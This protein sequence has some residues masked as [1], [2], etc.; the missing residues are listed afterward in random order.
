[1]GKTPLYIN[2]YLGGEE[3]KMKHIANVEAA[4]HDS[5]VRLI[6]ES[7]IYK[8]RYDQSVSI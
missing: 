3:E 8:W 2:E 1:M 6:N 4:E 5:T 7:G